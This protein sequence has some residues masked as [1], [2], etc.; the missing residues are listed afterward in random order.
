[1][2]ELSRPSGRA[3]SSSDE[4]ELLVE[5]GA[6]LG[7]EIAFEDL[8]VRLVDGIRERMTCDRATIF[9]V[10]R[11]RGELFSKVAHLPEL[12]EIR[13]AL[14]Q[15]VA[16][17]VAETGEI[18]CV[19]TT[20]A[21]A[22]FFSGV[23]ELTGYR[24]ESILALPMIDR[25]GDV[26]GVVQLLNKH[27]SPFGELDVARGSRLAE[28]A[29]RV[30]EATTLYDDLSSR[31]P[32]E[33]APAPPPAADDPSESHLIQDRFN[34]IVGESESLREACRRTRKVAASLATVLIR[35]ESGTGK[36]LFAR[37][38]HVNSNRR[39]RPFVKVDC[40]ALP[41]T[42]IENELFGHER[43]AF[44]GA[45]D[46]AKGKFDLADGGTIF[47]DELGELPLTV[48]GKLLRALQDREFLRVGGQEVVKVDARVVAAT[49]RDLLR[50]VSD[51]S[52]RADLYYRIRVVELELPPLRARGER[53][54]FRLAR[55]FLTSAARRHGRPVP[56]LARETLDR[57]AAYS[58]PGNVRELENCMESALVVMDG[59][60]I[61]PE[62]LPLP[63]RITAPPVAAP[64]P[65]GPRP[66]L[67]PLADVEREHV[68]FVLDAVGGNQ[69]EAARVL[70]IGRNTLARKLRAFGRG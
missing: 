63:D 60:V 30:L 53:D 45:D 41:E 24:T 12:P 42:L 46:R 55:H 15:G 21:D 19:P 68:L 13:L 31:R 10:D 27:G 6:L 18:V 64:A 5:V 67:R 35:G 44:T 17:W 58:W 14:G 49:N 23:D 37:A 3:E 25:L 4:P 69:S 54:V 43:G 36:E 29:A 40:A 7:R 65:S 26:I 38:V 52:F 56:G 16:G 47:L 22:R 1:M 62:H 61:L 59:E 39:D 50:M 20:N 48:Q 8:L 33:P 11:A 28:E 32:T 57:L 70:G 51:G 9:L 2:G 66:G 34:R